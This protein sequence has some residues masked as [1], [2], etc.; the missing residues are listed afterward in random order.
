MEERM[1]INLVNDII[2]RAVNEVG[3]LPDWMC[4]GN[5]R[6][7]SKPYD[8][9]DENESTTKKHGDKKMLYSR[10]QELKNNIHRSIE[11]VSVRKQMEEDLRRSNEL[12]QSIKA[13]IAQIDKLLEPMDYVWPELLNKTGIK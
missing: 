10:S 7:T 9:I 1:K 11:L 2:D 5:V 6:V 12:I 4:E 3:D 8:E 13:T